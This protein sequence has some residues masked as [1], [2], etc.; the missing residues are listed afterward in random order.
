[1][2]SCDDNEVEGCMETEIEGSDSVRTD[3]NRIVD[4]TED[5]L[6]QLSPPSPIQLQ[7]PTQGEN[8]FPGFY[9]PT[10]QFPG[11]SP[12]PKKT[13]KLPKLE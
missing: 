11:S 13:A 8:V 9:A 7:M 10:S 5:A 4:R 2:A 3:L 6:K 1:M 12:P